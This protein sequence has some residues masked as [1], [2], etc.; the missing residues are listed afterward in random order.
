MYCQNPCIAVLQEVKVLT[1]KLYAYALVQKKTKVSG[2]LV[3]WLMS[4]AFSKEE[5][6]EEENEEE[7]EDGEFV[8]IMFT[9]ISYI[10]CDIFVHVLHAVTFS[11]VPHLNIS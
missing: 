6:E 4:F 3:L 9:C 7:E 11:H 2:S 5:E 10:S 8:K 1:N